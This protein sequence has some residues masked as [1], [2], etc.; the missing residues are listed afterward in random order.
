MYTWVASF[1]TK[2]YDLTVCLKEIWAKLKKDLALYKAGD[3]TAAKKCF[4]N[5]G[6]I[7]L[8]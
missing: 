8:R 3:R 6:K 7:M 4:S 2:K 5:L 1:L